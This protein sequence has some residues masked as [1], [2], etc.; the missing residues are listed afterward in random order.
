MERD[1]RTRIQQQLRE[2]PV[3]QTVDRAIEAIDQFLGPSGKA[4]AANGLDELRQAVAH[5]TEQ[6]QAGNNPGL[7]GNIT[8]GEATAD[9]LDDRD[10]NEVLRS[11]YEVPGKTAAAEK[12]KEAQGPEKISLEQFRQEAKE[13]KQQQGPEQERSRFRE[14]SRER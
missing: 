2:G 14:R 3:G 4:W 9:R 6:V 1:N 12:S 5:G 10:K 13:Q 11:T 8:T 7:W